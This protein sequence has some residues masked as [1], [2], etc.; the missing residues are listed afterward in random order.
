MRG[1]QW[2]AGQDK[3]AGFLSFP[4]SP[5]LSLFLR[6]SLSPSSPITFISP[7]QSPCVSARC[8]PLSHFPSVC[9]SPLRYSLY[10]QLSL[11][12]SLLSSFSLS[13]HVP[14]KWRCVMSLFPFKLSKWDNMRW[15]GCGINWMQQK[16]LYFTFS[17]VR[18]TFRLCTQL[19]VI[20]SHF[21]QSGKMQHNGSEVS[22]YLKQ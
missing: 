10:L 6:L 15:E 8:L 14:Q 22:D 5:L 4:L 17:S 7:Y 13:I 3:E 11:C 20:L 19:L 9:P 1:W 18:E 2:K 16:S 12:L 21:I